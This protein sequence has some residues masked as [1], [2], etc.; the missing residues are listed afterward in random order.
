MTTV[1]EHQLD[2]DDL[3]RQIPQPRAG[4]VR[5]G[6]GRA[7]DRLHVDVAEVL[8][9][10]SVA[11]ELRVQPVQRDAG[12]HHDQATRQVD[13]QHAVHPLER[14]QDAVGAGEPGERVP[15]AGDPDPLAQLG[16]ALEHRS[17]LSR[18]PGAFDRRR[19]TDLPTVP[20]APLLAMKCGLGH[21]DMF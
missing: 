13:L 12:L 20:V 5:A 17:H 6:R 15:R 18:S 21:R 16:G 2:G 9:R 8:E 11:V 14:D 3:R 4:A 19:S 10:E 1:G 7:R